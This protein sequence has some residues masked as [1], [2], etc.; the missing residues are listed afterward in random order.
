MTRS[1][2]P[3]FPRLH[4]LLC[5]CLAVQG[6]IMAMGGVWPEGQDTGAASDRRLDGAKRNPTFVSP[7]RVAPRVL[8][9]DASHRWIRMSDCASLHPTY[10]LSPLRLLPTEDY[11][12][13]T[14]IDPHSGRDIPDDKQGILNVKVKTASGKRID[15]PYRAGLAMTQWQRLPFAFT[16][17][18]SWRAIAHVRREKIDKSALN[19]GIKELSNILLLAYCPL[20][21][22]FPKKNLNMRTK[23]LNE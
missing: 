3:L 11:T 14:I 20:L 2:R 9:C 21:R 5:V 6:Q 8:I 18:L 13:V 23:T 16:K 10:G 22:F 4:L 15:L 19:P 1:F 12:D 7:R 17:R